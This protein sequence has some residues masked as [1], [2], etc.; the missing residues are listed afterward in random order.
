M[1]KVENWYRTEITLNG[2]TYVEYVSAINESAARTHLSYQYGRRNS[3]TA[4]IKLCAEDPAR[5][6]VTVHMRNGNQVP[7]HGDYVNSEHATVTAYQRFKKKN[8]SR[9]IAWLVST[10]NS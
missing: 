3:K 8:I 4:S 9:V 7:M 2:K 6:H 10:N 1:S 5:H